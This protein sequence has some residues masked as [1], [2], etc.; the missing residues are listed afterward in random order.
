MDLNAETRIVAPSVKH[1]A[2][3]TSMASAPPDLFVF[4]SSNAYSPKVSRAADKIISKSVD[5]LLMGTAGIGPLE[6][7]L[8]RSN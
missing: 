1:A 3:K 8:G 4:P 5:I 7:R 6:T 2:P